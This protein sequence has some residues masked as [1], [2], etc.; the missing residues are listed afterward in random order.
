MARKGTISASIT[1]T[2]GALFLFQVVFFGVLMWK[3]GI[4]LPIG[5]LFLGLSMGYNLIFLVVLLRRKSEFQVEPDGRLLTR[6]NLANILTMIRLT[7]LPTICFMIVL[8]R[9][10][11]MLPILLVFVTLVFLTDLLDGALSRM[12]H[13]VTKIGRLMDSFSDYLVLMVISIAFLVYRLI[14]AWFFVAIF[15]RGFTMIIGMAILT[16]KRG[17]LKPETS[18]IG[19]ASVF[20]IMVLYAY[21]IF[22]L[23][24][25]RYDWTHRVAE[26]LEYAV[27]VFVVVSI[28][29]KLVF[30]NSQMKAIDKKQSSR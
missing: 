20:A 16:R 2:M 9:D 28:V 18:F 21:E 27:G 7:S 29:D 25:S 8:A 26:I 11:R 22:T 10:Y 6:V 1:L 15:A 24:L 19:K 4:P 13:Q 30:F 5:L 23:V 17:Y 14:P 12:T 3:C